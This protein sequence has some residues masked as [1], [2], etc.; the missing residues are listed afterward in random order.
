MSAAAAAASSSGRDELRAAVLG[1]ANVLGDGYGLRLKCWLSKLVDGDKPEPVPRCD[2]RKLSEP[3]KTRKQN[4][5]MDAKTL[6]ADYHES[7]Q[8][9]ARR[10]LRQVALC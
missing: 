5:D 8:A 10:S 2:V 4:A 7:W 1:H 6:H 3:L 9:R